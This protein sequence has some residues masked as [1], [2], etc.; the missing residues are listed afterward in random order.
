MA[1]SERLTDRCGSRAGGRRDG[2]VGAGQL[3][4]QEQA[5]DQGDGGLGLRP[6]RAGVPSMNSVA[7]AIHASTSWGTSVR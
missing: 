5:V 2:G 7:Q 4:E 3:A 6:R 1:S